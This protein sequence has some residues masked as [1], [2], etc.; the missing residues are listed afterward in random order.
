MSIAS[1]DK[2]WL[3]S[4]HEKDH[5]QQSWTSTS[6]RA[7]PWAAPYEP[8]HRSFLVA[9][10]RPS[11]SRTK[12]LEQENIG[13]RSLKPSRGGQGSKAQGQDDSYQWNLSTEDTEKTAW[14][15][16][17]GRSSWLCISASGTKG[18]FSRRRKS[19]KQLLPWILDV[20]MWYT[21]EKSGSFSTFV[22]FGLEAAIQGHSKAKTASTSAKNP[23]E[24]EAYPDIQVDV[25]I[26]VAVRGEREF[27]HVLIRH[28]AFSLQP[29]SVTG[30]ATASPP[31]AESTGP[32]FYKSAWSQEARRSLQLLAMRHRRVFDNVDSFPL[33][34]F[35]GGGNM[36]NFATLP[37]LLELVFP[38]PSLEMH[39]PSK[40]LTSDQGEIF[41][42]LEGEEQPCVL[43]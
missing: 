12:R 38:S 16:E 1:G 34:S 22:A 27:A 31:T 4:I 10:L 18:G 11:I 19:S 42:A 7:I 24:K 17:E 40:M 26:L 14:K 6:E 36:V 23:K 21:L 35:L 2:T 33:V 32:V 3:F 39:E 20:M 41:K 28:S 9:G 5:D 29:S 25:A 43:L 30:A 8:K 37:C 15:A 13:R